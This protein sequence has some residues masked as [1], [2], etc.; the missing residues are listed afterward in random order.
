MHSQI[1]STKATYKITH[2]FIYKLN[3]LPVYMT[4]DFRPYCHVLEKS[5]ISFLSTTHSD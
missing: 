4:N 2:L 3:K 1:D 5:K